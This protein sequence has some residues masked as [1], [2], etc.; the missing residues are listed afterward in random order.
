MKEDRVLGLFLVQLLCSPGP[1]V[2]VSEETF[3]VDV[4]KAVIDF[5]EH[6][7]PDLLSSVFKTCLLQVFELGCNSAR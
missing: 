2:G 7:Q 6:P 3:W 4:Y 5:V 1:G